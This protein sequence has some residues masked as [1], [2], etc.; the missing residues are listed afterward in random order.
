VTGARPARAHL[1]DSGEQDL[2]GRAVL[3]DGLQRPAGPL[4]G[5]ARVPGRPHH[6]AQDLR[7][8]EPPGLEGVHLD[9][10][11]LVAGLDLAVEQELGRAHGGVGIVV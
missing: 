1:V 10:G 2:A 9:P 6:R 4:E 8:H 5:G 7:A 3:A 11:L